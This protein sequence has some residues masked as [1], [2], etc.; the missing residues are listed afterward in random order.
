MRCAVRSELP[1]RVQGGYRDVQERGRKGTRSAQ[2]GT[3]PGAASG[4]TW[5]VHVGTG[6]VHQRYHG[7]KDGTL[8]RDC[9]LGGTA[10]NQFLEGTV[11]VDWNQERNMESTMGNKMAHSSS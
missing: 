3:L 6:K 11:K 10:E 7:E 2:W 1:V 5:K 9:C 4:G 8:W